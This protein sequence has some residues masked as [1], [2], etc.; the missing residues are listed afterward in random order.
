[1]IEMRMKLRGKNK[2]RRGE[3]DEKRGKMTYRPNLIRSMDPPKILISQVKMATE[4][5]WNLKLST[6]NFVEN[7]QENDTRR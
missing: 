4:L 6:C 7:S 1:M 5:Q 3:I 2:G